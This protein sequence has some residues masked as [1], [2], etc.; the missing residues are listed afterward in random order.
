MDFDSNLPVETRDFE[1]SWAV[2]G[3]I[4]RLCCNNDVME[5]IRER[6]VFPN[7]CPLYGIY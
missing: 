6:R 5:D 3:Y 7:T 2:V 4:A 1:R